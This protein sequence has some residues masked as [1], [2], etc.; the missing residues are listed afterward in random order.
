MA[1]GR[2]RAA[3]GAR[4]MASCCYQTDN[5][6]RA[7]RSRAKEQPE[8]GQPAA[9]C[10]YRRGPD[11]AEERRDGPELAEERRERH[12]H[13]PACGILLLSARKGWHPREPEQAE[14][15]QAERR[16]PG[17]ACGILL[18]SGA[19][20]GRAEEA[21]AGEHDHEP[22]CGVTVLLSK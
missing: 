5:C 16:D 12:H 2:W 13:N 8:P 21:R 3:D 18:L 15:T 10:C 17:P 7:G 4:P 9:S 1:R 14:G 11:L 19:R 6:I 20:R 22:A